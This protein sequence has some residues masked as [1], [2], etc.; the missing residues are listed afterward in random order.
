M[1]MDTDDQD[2]K[3]AKY[4][5]ARDNQYYSTYGPVANP[6]IPT[7]GTWDDHDYAWNNMVSKDSEY[8]C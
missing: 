2:L 6:K 5:A 1:Y 3:R 8:L 7:T 4:N